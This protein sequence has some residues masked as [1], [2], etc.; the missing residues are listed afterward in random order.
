M[1]KKRIVKI[2][3]DTNWYISA[4]V[5]RKSRRTLYDILTKPGF[6]IFYSK[7]LLQEYQVVIGRPKFRQII[8]ETQVLRF[9]GLVLPKLTETKIGT[10]MAFSRDTKD[11]Y[12]LAMAFESEADYSVTGDDDLLILKQ[13]GQ[14]KIVSM[15]E[16][17]SF[18]FA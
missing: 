18:S 7:E 15:S 6:K 16:L 8:S 3:L 5:N 9:L 2:I 4:S 13:V 1:A 17:Q 10:T 12:L 14:T 11:N